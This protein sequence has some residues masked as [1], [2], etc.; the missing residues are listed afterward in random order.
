[1]LARTFSIDLIREMAPAASSARVRQ[2]CW[3]FGVPPREPPMELAAG[4]RIDLAP[5]RLVALVGPSGAGKTSLLRALS[6]DTPGAVHVGA[7]RF[8]NDRAV[9]DAVAPH[10]PMARALEIL[11]VCGLGEPRLW[12][13]RFCDLSDGER[14]RATLARA[15]GQ[16]LEATDS[17]PI[18]C[19]EFTAILH[20]R[21]A[22]AIAYNLRKLVT[23][24]GLTL[25]V[26]TT[27]E[28]VLADLQPDQLVRIDVGGPVSVEQQPN[29]A[30]FSLRRK[31]CVEQ[32][33]VRD[34]R[35]FAPMHYR[36]RDGLGFVDKVFLLRE[37]SGGPPLG[38]AVFAMAPIELSLRNR[39]TEGRFVRNARRLNRELRILRRLVMHPDV[40]GCG[41]GHWFV[42][43]V[44]PKVGTR[45]VECLA[46]MGAVNPVFERAGMT[47]MGRVPYPRGRVALLE[48]MRAWKLD[49][50]SPRFAEQIRR[51]PRVR[52]LVEQTIGS[53]AQ[54]TTGGHYRIE[55]RP[56][57]QLAVSFRQLLGE[58][59]MY[60]LWDREREYPR[61][62]PEARSRPEGRT[63][64][65]RMDGGTDA[66]G[67]GGA[68]SRRR[69]DGKRGG[70]DRHSPHG[71]A[72][73]AKGDR[74]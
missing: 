33:S 3:D 70:G 25:V 43:Q 26:A 66:S 53:W 27:H 56:P 57:A 44:L 13:R 28:D 46:A 17:P 65:E 69:A 63:E 11:T 37:S 10:R 73:D 9:V 62:H 16:A 36:H 31:A 49:P 51:C 45:F 35:Y 59:P 7:A 64:A 24:A 8:P 38:I 48:R 42:Q 6:E 50:F 32:G 1:M 30:A 67:R 29:N 22:R 47:S 5:G 55:G 61:Q 68:N 15:V 20:R 12:I 21:L 14:F 18:F 60:Y 23:R 2:V 39:A 58:P 4:L 72:G 40:R 74:G 52:R 41:L 34:Y 19:D 54:A 71:G